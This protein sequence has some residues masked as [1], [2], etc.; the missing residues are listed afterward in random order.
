MQPASWPCIKFEVIAEKF[1]A[2]QEAT[3]KGATDV[4]STIVGE[5]K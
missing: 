4:R 2:E 5:L 3:E 1:A